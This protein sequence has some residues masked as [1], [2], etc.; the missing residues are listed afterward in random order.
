VTAATAAR[1][2]I[3][4]ATRPDL[5]LTAVPNAVFTCALAGL[6]Q[7]SPWEPR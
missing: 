1:K 5:N 4:A 3:A 2:A 7:N 6:A